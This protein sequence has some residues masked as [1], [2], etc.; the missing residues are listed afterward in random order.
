MLGKDSV[1]DLCEFTYLRSVVMLCNF[2]DWCDVNG[3]IGACSQ[4]ESVCDCILVM[5]L[6]IHLLTD[7]YQ[8]VCMQHGWHCSTA[9]GH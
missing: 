4:N 7:C 3:F 2:N 9:A 1:D 6:V 5:M 8:Q